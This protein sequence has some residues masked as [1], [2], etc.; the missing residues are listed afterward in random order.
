M[1]DTRYITEGGEHALAMGLTNPFHM[2]D[3]QPAVIPYTAPY[4]KMP[5]SEFERTPQSRNVAREVSS[6]E[7]KARTQT[8]YLSDR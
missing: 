3:Q 6:N 8:L 5:M 4:A 2:L 7:V 1:V